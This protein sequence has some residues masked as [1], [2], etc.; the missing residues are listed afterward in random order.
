M[1]YGE[2]RNVIQNRIARC[3]WNSLYRL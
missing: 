1:S 2:L 3:E